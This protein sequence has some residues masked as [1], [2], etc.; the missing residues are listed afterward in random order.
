MVNSYIPVSNKIILQANGVYITPATLRKW[1]HLGIH[2]N[3]FL[4]ITNKLMIDLTEWAK[5]VEVARQ[6]REEKITRLQK[7]GIVKGCDIHECN[8][9]R[10]MAGFWQRRL[11]VFS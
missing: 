2:A 11:S 1:H 9:P 3:L 8:F 7:L 10:K 4:K 5:I 6:R